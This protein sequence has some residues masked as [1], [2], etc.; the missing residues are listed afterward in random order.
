MTGEIKFV[1]LLPDWKSV[2]IPVPLDSAVMGTVEYL[3]APNRAVYRHALSWE[4]PTL[5][6]ESAVLPPALSLRLVRVR[7]LALI[8]L[9]RRT[10]R[11]QSTRKDT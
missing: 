5:V 2:A 9:V 1:T 7:K 3:L 10:V 11:K 4:R 8:K 6:I